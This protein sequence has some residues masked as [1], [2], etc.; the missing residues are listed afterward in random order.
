MEKSSIGLT[1]WL[2]LLHTM[3][4]TLHFVVRNSHKESVYGCLQ[5]GCVSW[6]VPY[7]ATPPSTERAYPKSIKA[8]NEAMQRLGGATKRHFSCF[9]QVL[10]EQW[11]H[12]V[13]R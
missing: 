1:A 4:G 10:E 13:G 9:S 11:I 8:Y 3:R 7:S 2:L 6:V 12:N 5:M